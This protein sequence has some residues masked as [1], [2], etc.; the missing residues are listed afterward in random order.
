[1]AMATAIW[2]AAGEVIIMDGAEDAAI[3]TA[4][5]E[6]IIVTITDIAAGEHFP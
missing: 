6:V 4:G 3:T 2:A 1:M 5:R